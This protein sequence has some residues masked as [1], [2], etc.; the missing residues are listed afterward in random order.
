MPATRQQRLAAA[1]AELRRRGLGQRQ[2][3]GSFS[4]S[5]NN[6]ARKNASKLN[7][8]NDYMGEQLEALDAAGN[9]RSQAER[10]YYRN[11]KAW[12]EGSI[13]REQQDARQ[14]PATDQEVAFGSDEYWDLA[15][16]LVTQNRQSAIAVRGDVYLKNQ[17]KVIR[18]IN[19]E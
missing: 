14:M 8:K 19:P 13:V 17:G 6:W 5:G 16:S 1:D 11:G 18:V 15:E 12:I 10:S 7:P 2:G 4:Q 3:G 9:I